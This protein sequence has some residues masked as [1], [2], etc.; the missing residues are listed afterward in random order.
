MVG[1]AVG[2]GLLGMLVAFGWCLLFVLAYAI[3]N[4]YLTGHSMKPRWFDT[5]TDIALP[6]SALAVWAVT[7][8]ATWRMSRR[9]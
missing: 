8:I 2:A 7:T 3:T 9:R 6:V 4:L 5:A 1:R